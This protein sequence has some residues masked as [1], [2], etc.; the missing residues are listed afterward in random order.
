[1]RDYYK[2]RWALL[3][4]QAAASIASGTEWSQSAYVSAMFEQVERPWS[5]A[6]APLFPAAPEHDLL[7]IIDELFFKYAAP[8]LRK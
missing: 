1:M 5:N 8:S 7:D 3:L 2:A 6:T 4:K